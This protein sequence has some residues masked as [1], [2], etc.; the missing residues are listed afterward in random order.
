[1]KHRNNGKKQYKLQ[2]TGYRLKDQNLECWNTGTMESWNNGIMKV[3]H[4]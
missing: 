1:M 3:Q 2:V 4:H